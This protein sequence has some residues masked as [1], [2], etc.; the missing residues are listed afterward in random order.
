MGA[1]PLT[2]L[3]L[4]GVGDLVLTCTGDL[5]RNRRV[6]LA[7][8]RGARLDDVLRNLRHVAE[9]VPTAEAAHRLAEQ[10]GVELPISSEVY[11]VLFEGKP[12]LDAVHDVL[13]R[14]LKPEW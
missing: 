1:N 13:H 7:L 3:G 2:F 6:G 14:P 10:L 9:G 12:V 4:S 5:S 11:R 8:G